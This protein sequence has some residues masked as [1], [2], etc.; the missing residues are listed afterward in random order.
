MHWKRPQVLV[1]L[2]S[3][4]GEAPGVG[5]QSATPGE[6]FQLVIAP[7]MMVRSGGTAA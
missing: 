4:L 1:V 3:Q 6:Q 5:S 2:K 7:Q